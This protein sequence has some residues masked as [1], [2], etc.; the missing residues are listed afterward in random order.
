VS[1]AELVEAITASHSEQIESAEI[2]RSQRV[3]VVVKREAFLEMAKALAT[4]PP[5]PQ[6]D[7][8]I[9]RRRGC[10]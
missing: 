3:S 8:T 2:L 7:W 1:E 4:R 10:R 5:P 9:P 6:G